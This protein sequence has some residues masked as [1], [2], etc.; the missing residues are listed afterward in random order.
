MPRVA[1]HEDHHIEA[2]GDL[3][4]DRG[5]RLVLRVGESG[6]CLDAHP[7]AAARQHHVHGAPIHRAGVDRHLDADAPCVTDGSAKSADE[8]DLPDVAKVGPARER[9]DGE[10]ETECRAV[11]REL[12]GSNVVQTARLEHPDELARAPEAL[13]QAALR[14]PERD[15]LR[16]PVADHRGNLRFRSARRLVHRIL[17]RSH[18]AIVVDADVPGAYRGLIPDR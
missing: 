13:G 3:L 14:D 10:I 17:A 16:A 8:P 18:A 1:E 11:P 12:E 4:E 6:D 2:G 5:A 7:D 9:A 15:P